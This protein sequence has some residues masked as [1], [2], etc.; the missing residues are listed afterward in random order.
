MIPI[1]D[2]SHFLDYNA[3]IGDP[4]IFQTN[5]SGNPE[6]DFTWKKNGKSID[7]SLDKLKVTKD[8]NQIILF[9]NSIDE[10]HSGEYSLVIMSPYGKDE[11]SFKLTAVS[12]QNSSPIFSV[13]FYLFINKD[14]KILRNSVI[15][16]HFISE[17][18]TKFY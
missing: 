15:S 16:F 7:E 8:G 13:K 18:L 5:I 4:F 10:S 11:A 17:Y 2:K 3:I 14:L 9:I 12:A 1:I 6:P